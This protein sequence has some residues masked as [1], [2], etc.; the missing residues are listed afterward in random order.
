MKYI[1]TGSFVIILCSKGQSFCSSDFT[2]SVS[3]TTE[4]RP[5]PVLMK[6]S[7]LCS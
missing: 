7:R 1:E 4:A 5:V 6:E 2:L 3:L